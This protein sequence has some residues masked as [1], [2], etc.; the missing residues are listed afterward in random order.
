MAG[1]YGRTC[2]VQ[3]QPTPADLTLSAAVYMW[4]SG[5]L[6]L[7]DRT[8]RTVGGSRSRVVHGILRKLCQGDTSVCS[9]RNKNS[10]PP[11]QRLCT[12][13]D[14]IVKPTTDT[15][16]RFFHFQYRPWLSSEG[17]A[18]TCC[19]YTMSPVQFR[20]YLQEALCADSVRPCTGIS[21]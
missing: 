5:A 20:G 7:N 2:T 1:S 21:N 12:P 15:I 10:Q 3:H 17:T 8:V 18:D 9:C 19:C 11:Y 4:G 16:R 13:Y 14:V 6:K